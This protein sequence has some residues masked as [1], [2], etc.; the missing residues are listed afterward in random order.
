MKTENKSANVNRDVAQMRAIAP[1][2]RMSKKV[3]IL[4]GRKE[5]LMKRLIRWLCPDQRV[6][7]RLLAP[8]LIAYLGTVR[9][10]QEFQ[11][12]DFS[13]GGF[14]MVTEERWIPGTSLPVTLERTDPGGMGRCLSITATVI[15]TG[16][17]GVGFSFVPPVMVDSDCESEKRSSTLV[18]LSNFAEFLKGLPYPQR[19]AE[20]L[21]RAS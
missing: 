8:P 9:G 10:S 7:S 14:Y 20:A 18:H 4:P 15:R 21:K 1:S 5:P 19:G 16:E 3:V 6:A 17:D 13:V 12:G 11:I 2:D